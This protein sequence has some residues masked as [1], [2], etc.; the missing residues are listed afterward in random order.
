VSQ[1]GYHLPSIF[2]CPPWDT[3]QQK[4]LV[5]SHGV[6]R[7]STSLSPWLQAAG[8][9]PVLWISGTC[10]LLS[11]WEWTSGP[12]CLLQNLAP[13][14]CGFGLLPQSCHLVSEPVCIFPEVSSIYYLSLVGIW[15]RRGAVQCKLPG[16]SWP[17]VLMGFWETC[18]LSAGS[19]Q[20]LLGS[21]V[22]NKLSL[23][24]IFKMLFFSS[25]I[26]VE[27]RHLFCEDMRSQ[28][29]D[30]PVQGIRS[31]RDFSSVCVRWI[32]YRFFY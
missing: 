26:L 16:S 20:G 30:R 13:V 24:F 22:S 32:L 15:S 11:L 9:M 10:G 12:H 18:S 4:F 31:N 21:P 19:S 1:T 29:E 14:S 25:D 23:V 2:L 27:W 17:D 5:F 28:V 3:G 6:Q 8:Q 7:R